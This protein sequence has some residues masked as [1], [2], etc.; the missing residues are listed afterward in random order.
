MLVTELVDSPN[1]HIDE[2]PLEEFSTRENAPGLSVL[3]GLR[4]EPFVR[5]GSIA[6]LE[7]RTAYLSAECP[8][9]GDCSGEESSD[10]LGSVGVLLF[11]GCKLDP[12]VVYNAVVR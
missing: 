2:L 3:R 12:L 10:R 5:V 11:G 1:L 7:V 9:N 6:C 8:G 4:P